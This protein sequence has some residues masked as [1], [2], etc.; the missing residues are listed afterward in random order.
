M[1]DATNVLLLRLVPPLLLGL[2]ACMWLERLGWAAAQTL[3]LVAPLLLCAVAPASPQVRLAA[4]QCLRGQG[5]VC[6]VCGSLHV[7]RRA[8]WLWM[9]L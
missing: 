9:C 7:L 1:A 2:A 4:G 3:G 5:S 6:G 8:P